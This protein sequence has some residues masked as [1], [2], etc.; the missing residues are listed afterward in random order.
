L[1]EMA[2]Q[3]LSG[4]TALIML[5]EVVEQVTAGQWEP[6]ELAAVEMV[7]TQERTR[8]QTL[9]AAAVVAIQQEGTAGRE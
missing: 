7:E 1:P 2:E 5:A 8:R 9:A 6:V 3:E 4:V